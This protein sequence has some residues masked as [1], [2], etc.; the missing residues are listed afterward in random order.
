MGRPE[1]SLTTRGGQ[2]PNLAGVGAMILGGMDVQGEEKK[3]TVPIPEPAA[4]P[5]SSVPI[6][7]TSAGLGHHP[8]AP[9]LFFSSPAGPPQSALGLALYLGK[10]WVSWVG[11][12]A[13]VSS[14]PERDSPG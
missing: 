6:S 2:A 12:F 10:Q 9:A 14:G 1:R 7:L 4:P 3:G 8:R 5:Q 11:G 13:L